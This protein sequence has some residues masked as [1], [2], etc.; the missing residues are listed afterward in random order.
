VIFFDEARDKIKILSIINMTSLFFNSYLSFLANL[1]NLSLFNY[2]RI[3]R[4]ARIMSFALVALHTFV[5]IH[6]NFTYFLRV[7]KNLY[8]LIVSHMITF[9]NTLLID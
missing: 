4:F 3:H 6:H 7:L 9:V 5:A 8:L 2:R 1:L